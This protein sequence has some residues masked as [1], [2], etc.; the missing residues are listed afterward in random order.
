MGM[1]LHGFSDHIGN[2][3]ETA[4]IHIIQGLQNTTLNRLQAVTH[5]RDGTFFNY[6]G[7]ILHEILIKEFM[8]FSEVS[9]IFHEMVFSIKI[10]WIAHQERD[11][12]DMIDIL[13]RQIIILYEVIH[14]ILSTLRSIFPHVE[15]K[16]FGNL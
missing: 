15:I 2:L 16:Y 12:L 11:F 10:L 7:S 1:Q 3:L 9:Y 13:A 8:E 4:I 5:V 14:Y 6:I